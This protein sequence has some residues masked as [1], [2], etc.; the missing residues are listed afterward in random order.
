MSIEKTNNQTFHYPRFL[1]FFD[2]DY[3]YEGAKVADDYFSSQISSLS[4]VKD[5]N[6]IGNINATRQSLLRAVFISSYATLEQNLDEI[7]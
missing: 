1:S 2:F 5:S 4:I 7:M 3:L 6:K